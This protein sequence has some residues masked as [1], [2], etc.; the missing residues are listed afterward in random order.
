M[1]FT[2]GRS[3]MGDKES[4][5]ESQIIIIILIMVMVIV[6]RPSNLCERKR[7]IFKVQNWIYAYAAS[8]C[9]YV[10]DVRENRLAENGEQHRVWDAPNTICNMC[11][12]GRCSRCCCIKILASGRKIGLIAMPV[13]QRLRSLSTPGLSWIN[14]IFQICSEHPLPH[15]STHSQWRR[16]YLLFIFLRYASL[17]SAIIIIADRI[18]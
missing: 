3:T 17:G 18:K 9:A 4:G 10:C 1:Q 2:T 16:K 13:S 5:G 14:F 15:A 12:A 6:A 7:Y 8:T 11:G